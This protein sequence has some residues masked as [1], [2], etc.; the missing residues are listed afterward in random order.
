MYGKVCS[1]FATVKENVSFAMTALAL[2]VVSL[3]SVPAHAAEGDITIPTLGVNWDNV[4]TQIMSAL[5]PAMMAAIGIALGIFVVVF[6]LR[7]LF[8]LVNAA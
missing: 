8:R 6:G 7:L 5:N 4:A 1:L 2:G 3:L